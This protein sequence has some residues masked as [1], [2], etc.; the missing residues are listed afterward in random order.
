MVDFHRTTAPPPH[1]PSL[2]TQLPVD[3]GGKSRRPPVFDRFE[4]VFEE[5]IVKMNYVEALA[6]LESAV[7]HHVAVNNGVHIHYAAAG[8]GPLIV[9]IHG[10]PDHWLTW[11]QQMATFANAYRAIAIDQRGFNLSHL[12]GDVA[13][14]AGPGA[15]RSGHIVGHD[16][17]GYV[18]G[19]TAAQRKGIAV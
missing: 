6:A 19:H 15:G 8:Q 2:A 1:C 9:F 16:W 12:F 5:S 17:G 13:G 18:A 10:F 3:A 11:W 4:A 14:S 7:E